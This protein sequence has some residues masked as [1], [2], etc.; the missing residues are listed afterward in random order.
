[1][2]VSTD[3]QKTIAHGAATGAV[4]ARSDAKNRTTDGPRC[5]NCGWRDV[6]FAHLRG[7]LDWALRVVS[8]A[9]FRCRSCGHRFYRY[10]RVEQQ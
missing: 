10:H 2:K 9:A 4:P 3:T 8:V 1:M 6:R 5:P 7:V